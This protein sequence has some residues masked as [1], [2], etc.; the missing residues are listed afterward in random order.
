MTNEIQKGCRYLGLTLHDHIIVGAG[1]E[2]SLR[3]LGKL[4]C[5][6]MTHRRRPFEEEGGGLVFDEW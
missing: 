3:A 2:L 1:T 4:W 6:S 5:R